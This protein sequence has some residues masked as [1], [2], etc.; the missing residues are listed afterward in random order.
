MK[1][2]ERLVD[3]GCFTLANVAAVTGNQDTAR[4]LLYAYRKRGLVQSVRRDLYVAMSLETKQPVPN[5]YRIA[6]K[7]SDGAYVSHH[8]AFEVHGVANQVYYEVYASSEK[9][10]APFEFDGVSYT[11]VTP[12]IAS[13]VT[14]LAGGVRVTDIERAVLDGIRDFEKIGGLE[15]TLKCIG[16]IP[17]L[18]EGK[19]LAYLAEYGSGYLYQ[20]TGYLLSQ[21]ETLF[22]LSDG[23]F[24]ACQ[25]KIPNA[26]R[27]L[28]H[29][30][31]AEDHILNRDWR[32]YVPEN[33]I[34][35][36]IC[37][38]DV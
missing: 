16:L 36:D 13:G 22:M 27:Y 24:A 6:S 25:S 8:S 11:R 20:R 5:R 14:E 9:R 38:D 18:D 12:G 26:K 37:G 15:E 21:S 3:M 1:H 7:A 33:L 34:K 10:F 28:H 17:R 23:F 19:L 30:V 2:Y 29:G 31:Q 35:G 4:S 32:L